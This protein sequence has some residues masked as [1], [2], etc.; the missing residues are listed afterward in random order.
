[1]HEVPLFSQ[2]MHAREGFGQALSEGVA[3]FGL[4]LTIFAVA[5]WRRSA[6]PLAVG[7]Y[8]TAAYW[9][10]S[11]TS[12]ANPAVTLA[13]AATA[14]FTGIRAVDVPAFIAAQ[15]VGAA[16]AVLFFRWVSSEAREVDALAAAAGASPAGTDLPLP[17]VRCG[18]AA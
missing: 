16:V 2:S 12:F 10:T 3:T 9:F 6:V 7:S 5:R 14:T 8:I 18:Q 1:M 4:V 13:R 17:D 15:L 11:S